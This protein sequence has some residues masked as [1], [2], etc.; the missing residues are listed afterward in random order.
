LVESL[1]RAGTDALERGCLRSVWKLVELA[2]HAVHFPSEFRYIG[3][4]E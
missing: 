4:N 3:W 1:H 2:V